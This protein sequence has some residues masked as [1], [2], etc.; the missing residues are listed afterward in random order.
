MEFRASTGQSSL[1]RLGGGG[2]SRLFQLLGAPSLW[3][4]P[5]HLFIS[6]G[7]CLHKVPLLSETPVTGWGPTLLQRDHMVT[8]KL[9]N[10]AISK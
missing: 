1:C 6:R 4:H 9:C 7:L 3:L 5:S 2:P 8:P 10:D